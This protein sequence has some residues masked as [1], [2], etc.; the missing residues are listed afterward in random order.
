MPAVY[1]QRAV[2]ALEGLRAVVVLLMQLRQ[3]HQELP[4]VRVVGGCKS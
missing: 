2:V 1:V 4:H 3:L